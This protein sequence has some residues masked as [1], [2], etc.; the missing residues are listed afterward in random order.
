M[1]KR[2]RTTSS[3]A[4]IVCSGCHTSLDPSPLYPNAPDLKGGGI[5][6]VCDRCNAT[7]ATTLWCTACNALSIV[8]STVDGG[9][10]PRCSS[11]GVDASD[12]RVRTLPTR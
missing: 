4:A 10:V 2:K 6:F 1:F 7:I 8:D 3:T 12:F 5:R 11:C 9:L